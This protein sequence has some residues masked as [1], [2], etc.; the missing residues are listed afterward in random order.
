[1][2]S[3]SKSVAKSGKQTTC[4]HGLPGQQRKQYKCNIDKKKFERPSDA[5][6]STVKILF[7]LKLCSGVRWW[8]WWGGS[9]N[10]NGSRCGSKT[11]WVGEG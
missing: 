4:F 1:M 10:P 8:W 11:P 6:I 2:M 5:Y 7:Q 9:F 3:F